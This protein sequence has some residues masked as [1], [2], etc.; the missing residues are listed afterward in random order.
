MSEPCE[1][2]TNYATFGVAVTLDNDR[3]TMETVRAATF[4]FIETAPDHEAVKDGIWTTDQAARFE[5][6]DF[7]KEYAERLV[8]AT[9]PGFLTAQMAQAGLSEVDWHD[10]ANTY[11][12]EAHLEM[13]TA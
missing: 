12:D 10:L 6:A 9:N 8:E 7:L 4:T 11:I 1:G 5:L 2:Y 3:T 13:E